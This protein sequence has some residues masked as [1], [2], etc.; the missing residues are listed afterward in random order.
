MIVRKEKKK[1]GAMDVDEDMGSDGESG[2]GEESGSEDGEY[3]A[4]SE[5]EMS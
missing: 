2:S 4:S 5:E 1:K 3:A